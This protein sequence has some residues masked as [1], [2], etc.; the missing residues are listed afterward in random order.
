MIMPV[1]LRSQALLDI[2][3]TVPAAGGRS[4]SLRPW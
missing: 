2:P 3:S 4:V 1:I